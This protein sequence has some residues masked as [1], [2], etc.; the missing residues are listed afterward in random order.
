MAKIFDESLQRGI[1]IIGFSTDCDARYLRTMRLTTNYFAS[2]PNFD[3]RQRSDVFKIKLP[4][5]WNWFYLDS[6]QLFL[7][8][9]VGISDVTQLTLPQDKDQSIERYQIFLEFCYICEH[10]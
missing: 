3:F 8:F 10:T 2:L 7:V 1:R 6:T 9:Q 4:N 5:A